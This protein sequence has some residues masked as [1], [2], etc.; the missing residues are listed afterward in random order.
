MPQAVEIRVLVALT[1]PS[2]VGQGEGRDGSSVAK[3]SSRGFPH[4]AGDLTQDRDPESSRRAGWIAA[5]LLGRRAPNR[6]VAP[7]AGR[8]FFE[9]ASRT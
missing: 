8:S 1:A 2:E 9:D 6:N 4:R 5:K 7:A 3:G